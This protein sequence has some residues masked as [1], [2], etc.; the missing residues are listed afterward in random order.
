MVRLSSTAG[1][2][3]LLTFAL[4]V[5]KAQAMFSVHEDLLAYPQYEVRFPDSP[6]SYITEEEA[7]RKIASMSLR[8]KQIPRSSSSPSYPTDG[9]EPEEVHAV[10]QQSP[11]GGNNDPHDPFEA[12]ETVYE[13]MMM[14]NRR[15]LCSIP[16]VQPPPKLNATERRK[17][18]DDEEKELARATVSGTELLRGMEG[19]CLYFISGWWSYSF[20]YNDYIK[21]FHQLPPANGLPTIPP[22]EDPHAA[23]YILGKASVPDRDAKPDMPKDG[24]M[25]LQANGELKYLVQKLAG[26]TLCD[27]TGKERRIELQYHCAPNAS[28]DRIGY[29]KEVTTCCY[30]MVVHTPRLC[31]DPAFQ[32]PAESRAN[33]IEC[34][35]VMNEERIKQYRAE[36]ER[37]EKNLDKLLDIVNRELEK[38]IKKTMPGPGK[39]NEKS[40]VVKPNYKVRKKNKATQEGGKEDTYVLTGE[41]GAEQMIMVQEVDVDAAMLGLPEGVQVV[42]LEAFARMAADAG[43][44][45]NGGVSEE[46][47]KQ[48]EKFVEEQEKKAA[49]QAKEQAGGGG[50]KAGDKEGEG[51]KKH[52][53]L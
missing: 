19:T 53:E 45:V 5:T 38:G 31:S 35:E 37:Q 47:R 43:I 29:I 40:Y 33:T 24:L 32:P 4:T 9:A 10:Q 26:G 22:V 17:N 49:A 28:Q 36:K 12:V 3:A 2:A 15:Y 20:C 11:G 39:V 41:D 42:D 25:E 27:I 52:D 44:N 14:N 18:K 48:A 1:A 13:A 30:L 21:Q 8:D 16:V 51:E 34:L 50:K 7:N 46:V 23:S 6:D